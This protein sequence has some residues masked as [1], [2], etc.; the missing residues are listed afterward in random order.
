[1]E[2]AGRV[3]L[4]QCDLFMLA[5]DAEAPARLDAWYVDSADEQVLLSPLEG[6]LI[7]TGRPARLSF[8]FVS[9]DP[10][11]GDPLPSGTDRLVLFRRAVGGDQPLGAEVLRFPVNP[12]D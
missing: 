2:T 7:G 6:F 3:H 5:V 9:A 11:T 1:V 10:E 4:D 8:T 12:A